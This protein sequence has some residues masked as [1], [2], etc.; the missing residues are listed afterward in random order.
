MMNRHADSDQHSIG[1]RYHSMRSTAKA[2]AFLL[3]A[4]NTFSSLQY[5][6]NP[7]T[8][9]FCTESMSELFVVWGFGLFCLWGIGMGFWL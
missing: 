4:E 9:P 3:S 5:F 6:M 2:T 7:D 1:V 8:I